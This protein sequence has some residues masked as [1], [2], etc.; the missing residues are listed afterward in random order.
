MPGRSAVNPD[1][2][3]NPGVE[4]PGPTSGEAA[5][6]RVGTLGR[7]GR[8]GFGL[9]FQFGTLIALFFAEH[10]LSGHYGQSVYNSGQQIVGGVLGIP[11][12]VLGV[13]VLIAALY[14]AATGRRG[15]LTFKL[16]LAT[17]GLFALMF[18]IE[19]ALK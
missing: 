16:A 9:V 12:V 18:A 6:R 17:V 8:V 5:A 19:L 14:T 1:P 2:Q 10:L 13:S 4:V 15:W 11:T 3:S 7:I